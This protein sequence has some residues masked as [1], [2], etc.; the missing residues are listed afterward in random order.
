MSK[1][2]VQS[3]TAAVSQRIR[4]SSEPRI[5]I[6]AAAG[7]MPKANPRT[8]CESEVNRFVIGVKQNDRERHGRQ[9]KTQRIQ[10][11]GREQEQ[12]ERIRPRKPRRRRGSAVRPAD[13]ASG[14]ADSSRRY[15][16][17]PRG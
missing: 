2:A 11:A 14:F 1:P 17:R 12:L 7:A 5:A 4:G 8:T 15:R 3:V 10:R 13:G 16:R 6:H 9:P